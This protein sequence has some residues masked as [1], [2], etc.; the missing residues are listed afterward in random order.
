M[1][2]MTSGWGWA[3]PVLPHPAESPV[4]DLGGGTR[5]WLRG[6]E[7]RRGS[8][9]SGPLQEPDLV[10]AVGGG[11]VGVA[12]DDE[13]V[14]QAQLGALQDGCQQV[15]LSHDRVFVGD[16]SE[17]PAMVT[18]IASSDPLGLHPAVP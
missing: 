18:S 12:G 7:A 6:E 2:G 15:D 14:P 4:A 5:G 3:G 9:S 16:P 1:W 17:A 13:R 10:V 8:R 11:R